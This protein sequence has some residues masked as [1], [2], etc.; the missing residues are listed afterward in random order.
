VKEK[1]EVC[2]VAGRLT[3]YTTLRVD[4]VAR[5][6]RGEMDMFK[7]RETDEERETG[8]RARGSTCVQGTGL[9]S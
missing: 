2:I 9:S 8:T 4:D 3:F 5:T 7:I 1:R 6:D